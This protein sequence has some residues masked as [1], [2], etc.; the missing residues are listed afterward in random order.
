MV[1]PVTHIIKP[2]NVLNTWLVQKHVYM[3]NGVRIQVRLQ[4][5]LLF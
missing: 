5:Y 2:V 4:H 1:E 3:V